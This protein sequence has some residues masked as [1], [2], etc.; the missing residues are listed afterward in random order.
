M[1]NHYDND[2]IIIDAYKTKSISTAMKKYEELV[3]IYEEDCS[4]LGYPKAILENHLDKYH[5]QE[6]LNGLVIKDLD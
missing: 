1:Q 4:N 6:S 3:Q 2:N 5:D